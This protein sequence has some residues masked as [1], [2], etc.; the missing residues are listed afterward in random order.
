MPR[1]TATRAISKPRVLLACVAVVVFA[2]AAA[3]PGAWA[4]SPPPPSGTTL[5]VPSQFA[6]L[7]GAIEAAGPGDVILLAPGTYPGG[8]EIPED[9]PGITI[10]GEDRNAVVFDGQ[11]ARTNAI[12]VTADGV[13]L[14]NMSAHNFTANGFYWDEVDGYAGR[15]LTVWNVGLYGIY[16]ISSRGGVMEQSHVS[17]AA[18]A[19]FYIGE[20]Q[21]CDATIRNVTA[22]L[23]AVGYSGT[24][25]GGNLVVEDSR[26]LLNSVGILPNS[27]DV[28][29]EPPPQRDAIF[30]RNE[31]AG[32]GTVVTPRTTPLGGYYGVGIGI[33]GGQGNLVQ[34]N[35]VRGSTRYGIA[36][37]TSIDRASS[38]FPARNEVIGNRVSDSVIADLALAGGT[39][40]QNCF[41]D[42]EAATALPASIVDT[43]TSFGTSDPQVEADLVKPP[44][45]LLHGLPIP[46]SYTEM[47]EPDDQPTMP[48]EPPVDAPTMGPSA[49]ASAAAGSTTA[50]GATAAA[51]ATPVPIPTAAVGEPVLLAAILVIVAVFATVI[52]LVAFRGVRGQAG[53]P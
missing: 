25:A 13:T 37:F 39:G 7:E 3:T 21:P 18:D 42:N 20:C 53:P 50:P 41:R 11:D 9:R 28:G 43:C 49:G 15:Y 12:E 38:W 47:A 6:D 44:P 35:V 51:G 46:P 24:N 36:V 14:E 4:A 16:A 34:D 26:F 31:V 17:G 10:R 40:A 19:A 27:F 48:L 29:L 1:A 52:V 2:L 5:R 22:T 45:E 33:A 32:S 30:R 23:S 8:I